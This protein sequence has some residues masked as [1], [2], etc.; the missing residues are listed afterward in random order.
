MWAS[1]NNWLTF[2][3]DA[4]GA[5]IPLPQNS[6]TDPFILN[7]GW[8]VNL[9]D[10]NTESEYVRQRIADYFTDLLSIGFSGFRMDAAKHISPDNLAQI[11]KKFKKNLG[12][13]DLPGKARPERFPVFSRLLRADVP[14]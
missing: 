5:P 9:V 11:F 2:A 10:L 8:L 6:W 3:G 14:A 13:N 4:A 1:P 12:G 7:Y